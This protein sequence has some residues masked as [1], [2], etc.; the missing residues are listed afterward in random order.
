MIQLYPIR[1]TLRRQILPVKTVLGSLF[2][3]LFLAGCRPEPTRQLITDKTLLDSVRVQFERREAMAGDRADTLF[4]VF[5]RPLSASQKEALQFLYA[6]SPLSDLANLDGSY[7][8][9]Q[10]NAALAA[11]DT[12][13][14]GSQIPESLFL[15]FVLPFRVNNENPDTARQYIFA[16]LKDRVKHLSLYDAALEVNHWCHEKVTYRASDGRTSAPLAT[17]RTAW[18]R[19]GEESTLTVAALRAV[20]IPARQV[21]TPRWAHTDDNHAWVE[22]WVDGVWYYMGACEPEPELNMGWFTM[23]SKRAMMVHTTVMGPYSGNE[24]VNFGCPLYVRVNMLSNYAPVRRLYA[25]VTDPSGQPVK[26]AKVKFKLY[27]Y[28]E[29][30]P[31][32]EQHTNSDGLASVTTGMGDLF[33]WASSDSLYGYRKIDGAATDTIDVALNRTPGT[34]YSEAF[35]LV[36]PPIPAVASPDSAKTAQNNL[37]LAYEDAIRNGYTAT[38]IRRESALALARQLQLDTTL[39]ANLLMESHGNWREMAQ[40]LKEESSHPMALPLLASLSQKDLRDVDFR[41]LSDHLHHYATYAPAESPVSASTRTANLTPSKTQPGLQPPNSSFWARYVVSPRIR[42]EKLTPFRSFLQRQFGQGFA[43]S[44]QQN[45]N[46]VID[47]ITRNIRVNQTDNY[48]NCPMSAPGVYQMRMADSESR[49]LFFVALC[50]SLSIPA[51]LEPATAVPQYFRDGA[52]REIRFDPESEPDKTGNL[53]ITHI[54]SPSGA[55]IYY[56][57]FTLGRFENGDFATLDYE[58]DPALRRFPV[59]LTLKEG[60]Y[61]L[62]SGNRLEDGTVLMHTEY[63]RIEAGLPATIELQVRPATSYTSTPLANVT[64]QQP[65]V[66]PEGK[67]HTPYTRIGPKGAI[68]IF[69]HPNREPSRHVIA[70]ISDLRESFEKWGGNV[71]FVIPGNRPATPFNRSVYG[72]LP[73]GAR[74]YFDPESRLQKELLT[75]SGLPFGGEYPLALYLTPEGNLH[76]FR[77]GYSIGTGNTLLQTAIRLSD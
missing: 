34:F 8:L 7:F 53:T 49:D 67:T 26:G 13:S 2:I 10:V 45:I 57:H 75:Q 30:Y 12:F 5:E 61:R 62:L 22:V 9:G 38:F 42:L 60:Y 76:A 44:A 31:L 20:G 51:R 50:R 37:R 19:C 28:A 23:P 33:I 11:R 47:W 39:T 27:N 71:L 54:E 35:D 43:D 15:H 29:L 64:L 4:S 77:E 55:P 65:L 74:F 58:N 14:W 48:I 46:V 18:G 66:D 24:E 40:W 36:P 41:V 1:V 21:Y 6:Y 17:I 52:W 69:I 32:A 25:R 59:Q 63:F 72:S 3:A 16:E 70:E 56:T 68:V 73:S